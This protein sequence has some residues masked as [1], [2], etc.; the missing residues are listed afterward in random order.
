MPG[1][2]DTLLK[3]A[4]NKGA[5]YL[6]NKAGLGE[7]VQRKYDQMESD[8]MKKKLSSGQI[9]QQEYDEYRRE[10]ARAKEAARLPRIE[11]SY[12]NLEDDADESLAEI[13][14]LLKCKQG[15]LRKTTK[16]FLKMDDATF[17]C[18]QSSA[19]SYAE[20]MF[21]SDQRTF[22][23]DAYQIFYK[24]ANEKNCKRSMFYLGEYYRTDAILGVADMDKARQ[25]YAKGHNLG[26]SFCTF[27]LAC[28]MIRTESEKEEAISMFKDV[29][30]SIY[31]TAETSMF[32]DTKP[33]QEIAQN[34]IGF[35]YE[36]GYGRYEDHK[37]AYKMYKKS[38]NVW[39]QYNLARCYLYGIGT[40]KDINQAVHH[41]K[42]A[43][44]VGLKAAQ[45][46]LDEITNNE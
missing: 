30:G 22:F 32:M 39:S 34:I 37:S 42:I 23:N 8:V 12:E 5:E 18:E 28:V 31:R 13:L 17:M 20:K 43:V 46:H 11:A 27:G 21:V 14:P 40:K 19:F 29:I 16:E 35:C 24:L 7:A 2:F 41:F 45:A 4:V 36:N 9:S 33:E 26:D 38:S 10:E 44:K 6:V 3:T 15:S 25:F 1:L